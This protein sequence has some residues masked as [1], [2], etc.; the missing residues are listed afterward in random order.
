MYIPDI[1]RKKS[2]VPVISSEQ[3]DIITER[4]IEEFSPEVLRTPQP[5][6]IDLFAQDYLKMEQDFHYLSHCGCYLGMT[7]FNDTKRV[8]VY[9]PTKNRAEYTEAKANTIIID[10]RLLE[11]N[12]EHRYRFTMG[13]EAGHGFFHKPYF[14]YDP[15]QITLEMFLDE[16]PPAMIQ[17]RIEGRRNDPKGLQTDEDWMEWQANA[18]SSSLLMNKTTVMMLYDDIKKRVP[19]PAHIP[20]CL[21]DEMSRFYNVSPEAATYRLQK[22][23]LID[24][25]IVYNKIAVDFAPLFMSGYY[26]PVE[27]AL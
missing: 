25:D 14:A 12:Q 7:V 21:A 1:K 24:Q 26:N 10:K 15:N 6:D 16:T 5:F 2:G 17:C 4:L 23:N 9:D 19:N 20:Y 27:L 22:L 3:I 18:F 11:A 13:H 8:P